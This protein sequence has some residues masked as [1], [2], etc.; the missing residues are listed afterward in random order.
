MPCQPSSPPVAWIAVAL[1]FCPLFCLG[2]TSARPPVAA[3]APALPPAGAAHRASPQGSHA[4]APFCRPPSEAMAAEGPNGIVQV[5][6]ALSA[7]AIAD[8]LAYVGHGPRI[9]VYDI[10]DPAAP[11]LV[12]RTAMLPDAVRGLAVAE[13]RVYALVYRDV[14]TLVEARTELWVLDA[15]AGGGLEPLG[16]VSLTGSFG[17]VFAGQGMAYLS[18]LWKEADTTRGGLALVDASDPRS[19]RELGRQAHGPGDGGLIDSAVLVGDRLV[20]GSFWAGL[21]IY[22]IAPGTEP[23]P[24]TS[25]WAPPDAAGPE[26]GVTDVVIEG[27]WALVLVRNVLH[28]VDLADPAS[29]QVVTSYP[30]LGKIGTFGGRDGRGLAFYD[31]G[32]IAL[33]DL[34][35]LPAIRPIAEESPAEAMPHSTGIAMSGGR[36]A[37]ISWSG[38]LRLVASD[39]DDLAS[40]AVQATL[41]FA[42]DVLRAPL[43]TLAAGGPGGLWA[44]DLQRGRPAR[45]VSI[46]V[47]KR[48]PVFTIG[49]VA[50]DD[51]S[52]FAFDGW[53]AD[54]R[55]HVIDIDDTDWPLWLATVH[56]PE[57]PEQGVPTYRMALRDGYLYVPY[58]DHL[59]VIDVRRRSAPE[60]IAVIDMPGATAALAH[61]SLL[62]VGT[63]PPSRYAA[64]EVMDLA[65]PGLPVRV[66][67]VS[68]NSAH[69]TDLAITADERLLVTTGRR[70]YGFDVAQPASPQPLGKF[71]SFSASSLEVEGDDL[72][73]DALEGV[74]IHPLGAFPDLPRSWGQALPGGLNLANWPVTSHRI[75]IDA[76]RILNAR[77]NLGLFIVPRPGAAPGTP[78]PERAVVYLP[79]LVQRRGGDAD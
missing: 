26:A 49:S 8:R 64:V 12:C 42:A 9:A 16:S 35:Q 56:L 11:R 59:T 15:V 62:Y 67:G 61:G 50:G 66:G 54:C 46:P 37:W 22:D 5:G 69:L 36:A 21:S 23:R 6:G 70:L 13:G 29:P 43:H 3:A 58:G 2:L 78:S 25:L 47:G 24:L 17:R 63:E 14:N 51:R 27:R 45:E 4:P 10:A 76:Q 68:F 1:G 75:A 28:L 73:I 55:I 33:L 20:T 32:R 65:K 38:T 74:A 39:R 31:D 77:G 34:S 48:A 41:P 57:G 72:I 7:V 60:V 79:L 52:A 53:G 71:L 40:I 18:G 19:P 30:E 44:I